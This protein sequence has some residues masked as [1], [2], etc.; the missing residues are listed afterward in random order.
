MKGIFSYT[1]ARFAERLVSFF[2]LPILT[3]IVTK[4]EYAIWTQSILITGILTPII[5]LKF[6]TTV[7]KFFP[8]WTSQ[9]KKENSVI[10]FMMTLILILFCMLAFLSLVFNKYIAFL[11][12]GDYQLSIY[13]PIV[14]GLLLSELLFEFLIALLRISDRINNLS[15]YLVAKSVWRLAIIT[16]V[17]IGIDNS[18]YYAFWSFVVF[19]FFITFGLFFWEINLISMIRVGLNKG[20]SEWSKILKFSFPLVPFIMLIMIHNFADRFFIAHFLGLEVLAIYSA[21][22]SLATIITFFH[23]TINFILFTEL[24]KKWLNKN[25]D[26]VTF[27]LKKIFIAYF[28]LT[29]PFLVFIGIAG[30]EFLQVL[31]TKDY[32]ILPQVL[33]LICLNIAIF[34]F[35]QFTYNIVLLERGSFNAPIIMLFVTGINIFINYILIPKIGILGS[36]LASFF[37][38]SLLAIISYKISQNILKYKFPYKEFIKILIRSLIMGLVIWQG[39]NYLGNDIISLSIILVFAFLIYILLDIFGSDDSSF[40]SVTKIKSFLK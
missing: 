7:V 14:V 35:Y 21:A 25:K 34:G 30:S 31:T 16:L 17:L 28:A 27:L 36:A 39:I 8:N 1:S 22:F 38:N 13:I 15:I 40:I 24:S 9:N 33:F 29:L 3:K 4:E 19:Q 6:E 2:L 11:I 20:R 5:L 18:F 23:S 37:S 32:F 12:F 10:L 26:N